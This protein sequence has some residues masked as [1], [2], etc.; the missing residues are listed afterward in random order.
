MI[1]KKGTG[2]FYTPKVIAEFLVDY[3]SVKLKNKSSISVLEPS[4]G[5]GIFIRSIYNN[6]NLSKKITAV[7]AVEKEGSEIEKVKL[8]TTSETLLTKHSDFF[9]FQEHN[10]SKYDLVI[11]NPPYFKKN[12]LTEE[13]KKLSKE[14]FKN[15]N[16]SFTSSKNIW[17]SFFVRSIF[18][19]NED[20]ILALILPSDLKQ[21]SF[22]KELKEL[23]RK[24]FEKVEIFTFKELLF[25]DC[26][27]QDTLLLIGEK[28]SKKKG[29]F[30]YNIKSTEELT[31]R[32]FKFKQEI[33][34]SE[35]KWN[36][37]HLSSDEFDFI[38]KIES[39]LK[40]IRH[41]ANSKPGIVTGAN[42]YFIINKA[43]VRKYELEK[44]VKPIIQSGL[45]VN[46]NVTFENK[47]FK[48]LDKEGKP[49][50]LVSINDQ[51]DKLLTKINREYLSLRETEDLQKRYKL[52]KR[53]VWYKIPNV[54]KCAEGLFLKRSHNYPKLL[55]NN[56]KI[57]STDSAYYVDM[58]GRYDIDSF[59]YSFYNSV[60]LVL[61]E[62]TGRY[63]GGGVLE[64]VPSE[65]KS[66]PLP[67]TI[68]SKPDFESYIREFENKRSI[69]D[70]LQKNDQI[71]L[72]SALKL[73]A[74]DIAKIQEIRLKLVSKRLRVI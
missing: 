67:Y 9:Q 70:I 12:L 23:L 18:F 24:E 50:Y 41:F 74:D 55:K 61:A 36:H 3:L 4:S 30:V 28:K 66:L 57:L 37:D 44:F 22:A 17:A 60:T 14:I 64:M 45:F 71:I 31:K 6:T 39:Q 7:V 42:S 33:R 32:T 72:R 65:F 52:G 69:D 49:T 1:N 26:K 21:V 73:T 38:S 63:Y 16:L 46:G 25:K 51:N 58:V 20:G 8:I 54:S 5:D 27:G 59:V 40:P 62:L 47:D 11:G 19:L 35:S 43:T 13:Q 68:I 15:A 53:R 48:I 2:S 56:A 29:V 10:L 34:T